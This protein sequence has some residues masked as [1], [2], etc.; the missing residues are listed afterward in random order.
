MSK[1]QIEALF[2]WLDAQTYSGVYGT[3]GD[4]LRVDEM[5]KFLPATIKQIMKD[6][7]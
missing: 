1:E 5:K 2:K 6:V 7:K 3:D 4:Y